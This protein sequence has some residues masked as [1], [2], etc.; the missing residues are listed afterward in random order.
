MKEKMAVFSFSTVA[1]VSAPG[2]SV[3]V[4]TGGAL[5]AIVTVP[6]FGE[7]IV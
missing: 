3:I 7:P 6:V 1:P 4:M 2:P 5:S